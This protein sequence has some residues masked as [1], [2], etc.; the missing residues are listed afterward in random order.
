M[1]RSELTG[2]TVA[3]VMVLACGVAGAQPLPYRGETCSE[4]GVVCLII[5]QP[6][7]ETAS[8]SIRTKARA[9]LTLTLDAEV[10]NVELSTPLPVTAVFDGPQTR[11][12]VKLTHHRR[13]LAWR[14]KNVRYSWN[15]GNPRAM[16]DDS[17][18]YQLPMASGR[19]VRVLQGYDGE[20][21]HSGSSRYSVDFDLPEGSPV[22]AARQG[23][24]VQVVQTFTTAGTDASYREQDKANRVLV[25]HPDGTLGYYGHLKPGGAVVQEGQSIAAGQLL[26]LS[27]NTGFSK[28]PHLHFEVRR[29]IDGRTWVTFPVRFTT[30]QGLGLTL[31]KDKS[32]TATR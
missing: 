16:H 8:I 29:P 28:G 7:T 3:L 31:E 20:F 25:R 21:S 5:E 12:L 17:V 1:S 23:V 24:V 15:W 13:E 26:G 32:Y 4:D 18:L 11:T 10:E 9:E 19:P 14:Y 27:G 2:C 22:H 30:E 6:D